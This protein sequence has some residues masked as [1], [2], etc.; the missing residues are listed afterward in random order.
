V[1]VKE[2]QKRLE[3]DFS[4]MQTYDTKLPNVLPL[5]FLDTVTT[6]RPHDEYQ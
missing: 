5:G 6:K 3:H 1:K 4:Y 2:E